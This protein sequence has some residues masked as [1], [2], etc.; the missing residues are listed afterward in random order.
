[1]IKYLDKYHLYISFFIL[2]LYISPIF[3][4]GENVFF[5]I[6]DG[7][8]YMPMHNYIANS[9][10]LFAANNTL[11]PNLMNGITRVGFPSEFVISTW[12]YK[13]FNPFWAYSINLILLHFVAYI[14]SRLLIKNHL[15]KLF[16]L[17]KFENHFLIDLLALYFAL[18]P[19]WPLGGLSIAGIPMLLTVFLNIYKKN[20]HWS[21]WAY[22]IVHSFYSSFIFCNSFLIMGLIV[23][24]LILNYKSR[25]TPWVYYLAIALFLVINILVEYRLFKSILIDHFVSHRVNDA[26]K[27]AHMGLFMVI[28]KT[29][30]LYDIYLKSY[31]DTP[32]KLFPFAIFIFIFSLIVNYIVGNKK[33]LFA[34]IL[35]FFVTFILAYANYFKYVFISI[36]GFAP[37]FQKLLSG[38][39]LRV[40]VLNSSLW[41]VILFICVFSIYK[42]FVNRRVIIFLYMYLSFFI[43]Y[44]LFTTGTTYSYDMPFGL[45]STLSNNLKKTHP[46]YKEYFDNKLFNTI[47]AFIFQNYNLKK[48]QYRTLTLV[49][50]P[51]YPTFSPMILF[52]HGFYT[53]DGYNVYYPQKNRE[54]FEKMINNRHTVNNKTYFFTSDTLDN[55]EVKELNL[56]YNIIK[57]NGGKFLFS[58]RKI[59][60]RNTQLSFVHQFKGLYW[61]VYLYEV[62]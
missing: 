17:E 45:E 21:N 5:C 49:N 12:L 8:E 24:G 38:V 18:L 42:A 44:L 46:T 31:M 39:T 15:I 55:G 33:Y 22:M 50:H 43:L 10:F 14:G 34:L 61:N 51:D 54:L 56:N 40:Y 35:L 32:I 7:I 2:L 6:Y 36:L 47:D 59:S 9:D 62:K 20:Y 1:M 26:Y 29:I 11:I 52:Y 19:H 16:N 13:V 4:L 57:E 48:N 53:L 3:L 27:N 28:K 25:K 41:L 37:S 60:D 23:M 58:L 30:Y